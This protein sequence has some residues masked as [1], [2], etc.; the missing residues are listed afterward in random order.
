VFVN[1]MPRYEVLSPEALEQVERGWKRLV[2]EIGIQF[3]HPR[4]CVLFAEAGQ[5]VDGDRVRF[6][7]EWVLSTSSTRPAGTSASRTTSRST[8]ATSSRTSR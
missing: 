5:S 7:P 3:D 8:R 6:D 1:R 2:S 4:A